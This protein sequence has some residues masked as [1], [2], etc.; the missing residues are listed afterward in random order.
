MPIPELV[1]PFVPFQPL[2]EK[3]GKTQADKDAFP[4]ECGVA[5]NALSVDNRYTGKLPGHLPSGIR[6]GR[7]HSHRIR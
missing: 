3:L 7:S 5:V 6:T 2:T 1:G 4:G